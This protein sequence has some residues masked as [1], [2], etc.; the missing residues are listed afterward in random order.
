MFNNYY[1]LKLKE[2]AFFELHKILTVIF[3]SL[4]RYSLSFQTK[5][6][7]TSGN[8]ST[9]QYRG[10]GVELLARMLPIHYRMIGKFLCWGNHV[11]AESVKITVS[12]CNSRFQPAV[13]ESYSKFPKFCAN[14]G[15][16]TDVVNFTS[17]DSSPR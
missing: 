8:F 4:T 16:Q 2:R 1:I 7:K 3:Q 15:K 6:K 14:G 13:T 11:T 12:S 9:F 5:K 10:H 17:L